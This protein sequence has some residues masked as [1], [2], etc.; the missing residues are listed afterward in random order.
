MILY[1]FVHKSILSDA[2]FNRQSIF[3]PQHACTT[4]SLWS[5]FCN[6][7]FTVTLCW[8]LASY[9][10]KFAM[11]FVHFWWPSA[12]GPA[13]SV[14]STGLDCSALVAVHFPCA[15][16]HSVVWQVA[17][18]ELQRKHKSACQEK[19]GRTVTWTDLSLPEANLALFFFI[20]CPKEHLH[21]MCSL[22]TGLSTWLEA[23]HK[24][25]V[26]PNRRPWTQGYEAVYPPP[27]PILLRHHDP[28]TW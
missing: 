10:K 19:K 17:A 7:N 20:F 6:W 27:P 16:D 22:R 15:S 28:R 14:L 4:N 24:V 3:T 21:K 1:T 2:T 5:N 25:P 9:P 18:F 11:F 13:C 23:Q 8:T 12:P 26:S